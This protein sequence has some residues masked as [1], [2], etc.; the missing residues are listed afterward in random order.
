MTIAPASPTM[1]AGRSTV[2]MAKPKMKSNPAVPESDADLVRMLV[3][4]IEKAIAG[5]LPK[6]EPWMDWESGPDLESAVDALAEEL[7]L[8]DDP[9]IELMERIDRIRHKQSTTVLDAQY[10]DRFGSDLLIT[11]WTIPGGKTLYLF[12]PEEG[13]YV[14]AAAANGLDERLA[15]KVLTSYF[16]SA[17]DDDGNCTHDF[18]KV[19]TALKL[20]SPLLTALLEKGENGPYPVKD[21]G[22]WE[23]PG[24]RQYS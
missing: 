13:C 15:L 12:E 2:E 11:A 7:G 23:A 8:E 21:P 22:F 18:R 19:N 16:V 3:P 1:R 17:F 5:K 24:S 4:H 9:A 14:L 20:R 6:L 10:G